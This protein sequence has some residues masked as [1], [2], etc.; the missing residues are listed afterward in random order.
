MEE[1]IKRGSVDAN[2]MIARPPIQRV[3]ALLNEKGVQRRLGPRMESPFICAFI[4]NRTEAISLLTT[5]D[6]LIQ[7][8]DSESNVCTFADIYLLTFSL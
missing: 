5:I 7:S 3:G 8:A 2:A 1:S 6:N 4:T